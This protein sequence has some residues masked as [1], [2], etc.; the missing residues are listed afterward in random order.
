MESRK[1]GIRERNKGGRKEDCRDRR[2]L[3]GKG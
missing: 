2:K 1:G 3:G